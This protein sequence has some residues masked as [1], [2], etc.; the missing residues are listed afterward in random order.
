MEKISTTSLI[1]KDMDS[2]EHLQRLSDSAFF[3]KLSEDYQ[4]LILDNIRVT[5]L[6]SKLLQSFKGLVSQTFASKEE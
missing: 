3:L 1:N 5:S 6:N 2:P 4:S